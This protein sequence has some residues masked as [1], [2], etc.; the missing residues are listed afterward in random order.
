MFLADVSGSMEGARM[1]ELKRA[2]ADGSSFIA[3]ENSIG[4][5]TFSDRVTVLLPIKQFQMVQQSAFHTAV[6]GLSTGGKTAMYDGISVS[7]SMLVEEKQ[8]DPNVKPVL[9]VL[10][11]GET[12]IGM[13]YGDMDNIIEGLQIPVYSIGFEANIDELKKLSGLVEAAS[14]NAKTDDVSYTIGALLNTQM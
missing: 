10:T 14:I 5:V 9:F 12:N 13:S 11:D 4:L 2:L 7:L 6:R 8:K 1:R 3:T